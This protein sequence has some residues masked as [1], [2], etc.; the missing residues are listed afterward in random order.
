MWWRISRKELESNKSEGNR[1]AMHALVL[2]GTVPG[3]LAYEKNQAIGWCA[4]APRRDLHSLNRSRILKPLDERTVWSI[5]CF[6]VDKL[7]R[8]SGLVKQLIQAAVLHAKKNGARIV[9]AY[10]HTPVDERAAPV[11]AYMGFPGA[12]EQCGF[13]VERQASKSKLIMRHYIEETR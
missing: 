10:P 12:F 11:T 2:G 9:E 8:N 3:I 6:Y 5:T 7:H 13:S 4:I 1:N